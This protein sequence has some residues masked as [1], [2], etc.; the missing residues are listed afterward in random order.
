M[1]ANPDRPVRRSQADGAMIAF[2]ESDR[3]DAPR[4]GDAY[5]DHGRVLLDRASASLRRDVIVGS[6]TYR[7]PASAM[8][9]GNGG[10]GWHRFLVGMWVGGS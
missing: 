3:P 1:L 9:L 4:A 2:F 7:T 10:R 8:A 5:G 6:L